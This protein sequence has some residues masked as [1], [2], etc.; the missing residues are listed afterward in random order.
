MVWQEVG[1]DDVDDGHDRDHDHAAAAC[2]LPDRCS[3]K[4]EWITSFISLI[5]MDR[6]QTLLPQVQY[7][8]R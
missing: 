3:G 1:F 4:K 2:I 8:T 6:L 5:R 7:S